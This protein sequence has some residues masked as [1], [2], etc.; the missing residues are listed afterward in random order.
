MNQNETP[1]SG[2]VTEKNNSG[3]W[4]LLHP[5]LRLSNSGSELTE[6]N[7]NVIISGDPKIIM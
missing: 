4:I 2:E 6:Q 1:S 7:I 5:E 3:H